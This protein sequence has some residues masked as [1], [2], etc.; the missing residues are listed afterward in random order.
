[1]GGVSFI[2]YIIMSL[3][4]PKYIAVIFALILSILV[5]IISL[6]FLGGITTKEIYRIP[7]GKFLAPVCRKMHLLN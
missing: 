2:I 7:G 5:Y 3:I 1:M 6:A 4:I